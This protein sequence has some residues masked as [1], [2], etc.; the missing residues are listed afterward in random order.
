MKN[1][2]EDI[3]FWIEGIEELQENNDKGDD[4]DVE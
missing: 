4:S 3:Q 1:V 2:D